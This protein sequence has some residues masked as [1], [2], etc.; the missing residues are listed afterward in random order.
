MRLWLGIIILLLLLGAGLGIAY[1]ATVLYPPMAELLEEA[2]DNTLGE[3]FET[4]TKQGLE[5]KA[6]WEKYRNLT[7]T[8]ADHTPMEEIDH[9]FVEMAVYAEADEAPHFAACCAQLAAMI[10]DICEARKLSL[11]N[12]L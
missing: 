10:R 8:V 1:G 2:A 5:A 7:A 11:W 9:L 12:L 6:L 3:K 4:G